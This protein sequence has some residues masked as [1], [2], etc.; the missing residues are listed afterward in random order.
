M[1]EGVF[2]NLRVFTEVLLKSTPLILVGTGIA[3]AFRC[4]IWNIGAEGQFYAGAVLATWVGI[5]L[6]NLPH[7]LTVGAVFLAG[8]LGGGLWAIIPGWLKIRLKVNEVVSTLMLNYMMTGLTSYLVTGPMQEA[9]KVFPQTD[10]IVK[11][12]RLSNILPPTR[13]NIGFFVAVL[14]A[15][16][17]TIILFRTPLGYAIRTVGQNPETARYAGMRVNRSII[18]AMLLSGG[19][20]GLAGAIEVSGLTWR[21]YATISPGY[22]FD[23]IAVSLLAAN[24][25]LGTILSGFLFGALRASSELMQM[26]A[27]IPSV[28]F[29]IIQGLTIAFVIAFS[30]L[31][32]RAAN[33]KSTDKSEPAQTTGS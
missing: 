18:I 12:A 30:L 10:E 16:V 28:L 5:H 26:N 22:G 8:I 7:G 14:V 23:G 13:L 25:P 4:G 15:I 31:S 24:N 3:I 19:A 32:R 1:W 21:M 20:A 29:K 17:M 6:T 11:A 27:R 33:E 2:G 9:K